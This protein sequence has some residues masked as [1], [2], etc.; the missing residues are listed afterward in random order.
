MGRFSNRTRTLQLPEIRRLPLG[1]FDSGAALSART[2]LSLPGR[3]LLGLALALVFVGWGLALPFS[4]LYLNYDT[5]QGSWIC[6]TYLWEVPV[7]GY[8]FVL[9]PASIWL[10]PVRTFLELIE[11]SASGT[12]LNATAAAARRVAL[13][14]PLRLPRMVLLGSVLGFT[15]GSLQIRMFA[16]FPL[17][18]IVKNVLFSI[19]IGLLYAL[20][21]YFVL[22]EAL[23]PVVER[24]DQLLP[25]TRS[26]PQVPLFTKVSA[27]LM[28][29]LVVTIFV[30]GLMAYTSSQRLLDDMGVQN[31]TA[32]LAE[33]ARGTLMVTAFSLA[34]AIV[35]AIA[36]ARNL[37]RPLNLLTAIGSRPADRLLEPLA[38]CHTDDELEE[39]Y[40]AFRKLMAE[41]GSAQKGLAQA[42]QDLAEKVQVRTQEMREQ[43]ALLEIAR[44][45]GSTLELDAVLQ[46]VVSHV[47]DFMQ[48]DACALWLIGAHGY[49]LKATRGISGLKEIGRQ[50]DT[51]VTHRRPLV[52]N[53][54]SDRFPGWVRD[55][56]FTQMIVGPLAARGRLVGLVAVFFQNGGADPRLELLMAAAAQAAV[57]IENARLYADTEHVA[58]L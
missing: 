12:R 18:E 52:L 33:T 14:L 46:A 49:E 42:N 35:L 57:A 45:V 11:V 50:F 16:H 31:Q 58:H 15:L 20:L 36:L 21:A 28:V 8:L 6:I 37:L 32:L 54:S 47:R 44:S 13:E 41:L 3:A 53:I 39:L 10:R 27:C 23:R 38:P 48:A 26:R 19:P 4:L 5:T 29:S 24:C 56:G 34:V 43:R 40:Q 30:M 7:L 25:A 55:A 17:A 22:S 9:L 2:L 51:A 1:L